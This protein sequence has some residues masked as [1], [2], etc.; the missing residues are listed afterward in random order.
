[1]ATRPRGR[2]PRAVIHQRL[3]DEVRELRSRHGGLP[4]PEEAV[5]IWARIW[6]EEAHNSTA[7]EGNTL[8]QREVEQLLKTGQVVGQKELKEY[9][10]VKR[11]KMGHL[12]SLVG[13]PKK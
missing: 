8:V 2:P 13:E 12:L 10:E 11:D 1:M 9:L 7:L 3:E 5:E 6:H 4:R